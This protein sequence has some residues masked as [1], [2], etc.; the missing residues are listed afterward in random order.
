MLNKR[1]SLVLMPTG[2]G[3]SLCYQI[4][5]LMME[6]TAVV[7]SPLIS[8][9]QDQVN[10]LNARGIPAAALNSNQGTRQN[11]Q[12]IADAVSGRLKLIYVSPERLMFDLGE[13]EIQPEEDTIQMEGIKWINSIFK[14]IKISMFA[15][16]EAHCVSQWGHDFRPEYKML[17]RLR[18]IFPYVPMMAL[19]ATADKLTRRDII[20]LLDLHSPD[21]FTLSF[22][23]PNLSLDVRCG[24]DSKTKL[25]TITSMIRRHEGESGI[26]Y[27]LA[28]KTTEVLAE[29]LQAAGCNAAAYHAQLSAKER[30]QVQEDFKQGK[31]DVIC[32]TIAFG[33]GID[34]PDVRFVVHYNMP[35]SIESFYQEIG[36]GGRDGKPCET[37]LFYSMGD[38]VALKQVARMS[39][40]L[41]VNDDKM[42]R[43]QQYAEA[44][45]CRRRILLNYF[46][47]EYDCNC[48]N[49]DVCKN[50][51]QY[52]DGTLRVQM[53][54]SAVVR[55]NQGASASMVIDILKGHHTPEISRRR[56]DALPT[57]GVGHE[58]TEK[59]WRDCILQMLQLGFVD[60]DYENYRQLK[61]TPL[62][63]RTL[64]ERI[65]VRLAIKRKEVEEADVLARGLSAIRLRNVNTFDSEGAEFEGLAPVNIIYG[66][67]GSGKSTLTKVTTNPTAYPD[68]ELEWTDFEELQVVAYDHKF[69]MDNLSENLPGVFTLGEAS[70]QTADEIARMRMELENCK[71]E[72]VRKRD[73]ISELQTVIKK[74]EENF[75][76]YAWTNIKKSVPDE[77]K[78]AL[79]GA[80]TKD[81]FLAKLMSMNQEIGLAMPHDW[82]TLRQR[83]MIVYQETASS[84]KKETAEGGLQ[85]DH[86][87]WVHEGMKHLMEGDDK[88]PF[89]QQHT[90]TPYLRWL[91]ATYFGEQGKKESEHI[92]QMMENLEEERKQ[93]TQ[94]IWNTLIRE[95]I[96]AINTYLEKQA[97]SKQQEATLDK[98]LE[99][100]KQRCSELEQVITKYESTLTSIKPTLTR[101]NK[102]LDEHGYEGFRLA[103]S[104]TDPN[105]Y[106]IVRNDGTPASVTLSEGEATLITFLYFM[107]LAK[108]ANTQEDAGQPRI[109]VIDDPVDAL[110]QKGINIITSLINDQINEMRQGEGLV[111]QIILLTHNSQLMQTLTHPNGTFIPSRDIHY[112]TLTKSSGITHAEAHN[113]ECPS[114]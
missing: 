57:F 64:K 46:N 79:Q 95:N 94:D 75:R 60:V 16:D 82:N 85:L 10:A 3:K 98:E 65:P 37:L 20:S 30:T 63:I 23:R 114:L 88:C 39:G 34:K 54:L 62:G 12:T 8:L 41:T 44:Q 53:A 77:F 17:N 59:E 101:I 68:C 76:E 21:L 69:R 4:P 110:D 102:L 73:A 86:P 71:A 80:M 107:Q 33:M 89:C 31:I 40:S 72:C 111:T 56:Y 96:A 9:M 108:G 74:N 103:E 90:V 106:Q 18:Q 29:K 1:D 87:D 93:L 49:C 83:A 11:R 55:T 38:I 84:T 97:S 48:G 35:K 66:G 27:C 109:L 81:K 58:V 24:C 104:P 25:K 112:W 105:S 36:R 19:T 5:A 70:A 2:G 47:E 7:V 67:N 15:I 42:W 78:M 51:P 52:I 28:R 99:T 91:L 100:Q 6:G 92:G 13:T 113:Q 61:I 32:A 14:Q 43:M 45:V 22:N 26:I 50:P